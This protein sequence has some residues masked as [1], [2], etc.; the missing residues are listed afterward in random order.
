MEDKAKKRSSDTK[1]VED[2]YKNR[3]RPEEKIKKSSSVTKIKYL[4]Q[5]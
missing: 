2:K 4:F 5:V 3:S 1:T